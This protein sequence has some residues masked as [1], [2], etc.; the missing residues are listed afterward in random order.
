ARSARSALVLGQVRGVVLLAAAQAGL[1]VRSFPPATVKLQVTGHGQA[2]KTQ[3]A[4]MVS[5][6]LALPRQ[7]AGDAADALAVALCHAHCGQ[8]P[9]PARAGRP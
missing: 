8:A 5:R 2:E 9:A 3:V 7:D 6:L 1:A 4:F